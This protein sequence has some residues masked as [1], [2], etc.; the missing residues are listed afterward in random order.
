MISGHI[1]SHKIADY[2]FLSVLLKSVEYIKIAYNV[3]VQVDDRLF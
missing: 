3:D 1:F 2:C